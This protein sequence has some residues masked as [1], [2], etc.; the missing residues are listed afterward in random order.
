MRAFTVIAARCFVCCLLMLQAAVSAAQPMPE[1]ARAVVERLYQALVDTAALAP[2]PEQ[3][4]ALLEPVV[5]ESFD[6]AGMGQMAAGRHWRGWTEEEQMLYLD[7][8]TR[9]SITQH[10]SNF[11]ALAPDAWE[12]RD[13]SPADSGDLMQVSMLIHRQNGNADALL[14]YMLEADG[15]RWRIVNVVSGDVNRGTVSSEISALRSEYHAILADG[16]LTDLLAAIDAQ[17]ARCNEA[18]CYER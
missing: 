16:G 15:E 11:A 1:D 7:A 5:T 8:F 13:S 17:V 18:A 4:F 14:D 12:V 2:P 10:A 6:L 3:R 9:L